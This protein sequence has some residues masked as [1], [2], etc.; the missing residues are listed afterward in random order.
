MFKF[1]SEW[2]RVEK[3]FKR[4][5]NQ[6]D[7]DHEGQ[8]FDEHHFDKE[9]EK[10]QILTPCRR[11]GT[12]IDSFDDE[13]IFC[14]RSALSPM[15][16]QYRSNGER[17]GQ[18]PRFYYPSDVGFDGFCESCC[19]D[20]VPWFQKLADVLEVNKVVNYLER[21]IRCQRNNNPVE[22]S[23]LLDNLGKCLSTPPSVY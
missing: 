17:T 8:P 15:F 9:W 19:H 6:Y 12:P 3:T 22:K 7:E 4:F 13:P 21:S 18:R 14:S 16:A 10:Q 1:Q 20:L 2:E 5:L 23:K 11:C